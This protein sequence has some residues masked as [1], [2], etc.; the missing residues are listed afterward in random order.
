MT[1]E[2]RVLLRP[3]HTVRSID[4][5][6]VVHHGMETKQCW[7]QYLQAAG[8]GDFLSVHLPVFLFNCNLA[9]PLPVSLISAEDLFVYRP[10]KS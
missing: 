10:N 2:M 4:F 9:P 3:R 1:A 8:Q 6:L 7:Q 5:N